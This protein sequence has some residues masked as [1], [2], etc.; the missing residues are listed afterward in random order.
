MSMMSNKKDS[1]EFVDFLSILKDGGHA[2]EPGIVNQKE[3]NKKRLEQSFSPL[4]D[5]EIHM[6]VVGENMKITVNK[7][8]TAIKSIDIECRCGCKSRLLF[9]YED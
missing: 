7:E 5:N 9:E 3:A 8:E 1:E 2:E 4:I 6:D